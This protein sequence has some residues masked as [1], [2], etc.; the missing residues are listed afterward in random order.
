MKVGRIMVVKQWRPQQMILPVSHVL[1]DKRDTKSAK[2][3]RCVNS[4]LKH[5][6]LLAEMRSTD[7]IT[8]LTEV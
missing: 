2:K 6:F 5:I 3:R 4:Q 7:Y 8:F 1:C